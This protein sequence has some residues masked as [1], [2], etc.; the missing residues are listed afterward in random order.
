MYRQLGTSERTIWLYDRVRPVHFTLTANII[1][2][3]RLERLEQALAQVQQRHPL[4]NV[5]IALDRTEIPWFITETQ[6]I[7]IRLVKRQSPQ[8]WQQEVER[9]LTNPF[10]WNQAPLIRVVF[11]QGD[12]VS[13]LIVT[14]H[15][16]IADGM[17]VVFLLRDIL[18]A[19]ESPDRTRSAPPR[20]SLPVLSPQPP[21]EQL[22]PQFAQ[23]LP[24]LSFEP[25]L[26]T[27]ETQPKLPANSRPRL[28]AWS[29]STAE[30]SEIVNACKQAQTSVHAAICA[31]FL[32]AIAKQRSVQS[33]LEQSTSL[34]CL[35]PINVRRFLPVI[36]EDFGHYLTYALTTDRIAPNLSVWELAQSIKTQL[37]QKINSEQIF[38]DLPNSEAFISTHPS[39]DDAVTAI[40]TAYIKDITVSN[41]GRLTIPQQ[42]GELQLAAVYSPSIFDRFDLDLVV[43]VMTLGDRM[44][45]SLTYS[46]LGFSVAQIEKFQQTAMQFLQ[47]KVYSHKN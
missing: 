38:A 31:A 1:G 43:G 27:I 3:V 23:K 17:S 37:D 12:D 18:Q 21:Y 6:I 47:G 5:K 45:F 40:E 33:N 41:L 46:E 4:L 7:P 13:D 44:F 11:I 26:A 35:S 42:Y 39:P 15:H 14:C 30:T 24:A 29:L 25:S 9:E 19:L 36:E 16:A 22:V 34:N 8:Q 2:K 28:Q 20:R 10:D 32:L